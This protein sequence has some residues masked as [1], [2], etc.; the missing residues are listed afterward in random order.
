MNHRE[1]GR[2]GADAQGHDEHDGEREARTLAHG[3]E[4]IGQILF[5]DRE[6]SGCTHQLSLLAANCGRRRV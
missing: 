4:G 1:H 6:E 3:A 5:D 2:I